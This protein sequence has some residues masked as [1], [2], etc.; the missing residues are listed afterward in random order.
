MQTGVTVIRAHADDPFRA[1]M[2]AGACVINGFGKSVGLVQVDELGVLK[3]PIAL[4]NTFGVGAVATAQIC[5]VIAANPRIGRDW[6]SVNPL[7]FE[8][9]DGYLNDMQAFAVEPAHYDEAL[10]DCREDFAQGATGA[11]RGMSCFEL[12]GGIGTASRVMQ[13]GG[14]AYMVGALVLANFGRLPQLTIAGE[15]IGRQ[16]HAATAADAPAKPERGSIII[17]LA[18]DALHDARQLRRV[19]MRAA[20][21]LARTGSS[22]GHGS[23]DIALAFYAAYTVP[24][25]AAFIAMPLL[26]NDARLDRCSTRRPKA[27]STRSPMRCSAR[28]RSRDA[29]GIGA[30]RSTI[31]SG[32]CMKVLVSV[33]IEGVAGVFH[34]EQ[35]RP[36]N[37][38]YE[39]ARR[40]ITQEANAAAQGAFDGGATQVW[41]NDLHGGLRNLL[42]DLLDRRARF[43]LGKPR[44]LGMM[45]ALEASPD[46]VFMVGYHA[47]VQS[48]G[49]LAHMINS[50]AFA[51]VALLTGDDVFGAQTLPAFPGARFLCVK[52]AYGY[53]SGVTE[54]PPP[55]ARRFAAPRANR[56]KLFQRSRN[57]VHRRRIIA[58]S[59]AR[60]PRRSR[61]SS[62]NGRRSSESIRLP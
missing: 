52:T 39:Q 41:I 18:T 8:C 44:T 25:D 58:A 4:T 24:H 57:G 51:C 46:A 13:A 30:S 21:G 28:K 50:A 19:A 55:H 20:A 60:N 27:S 53:S 22:F 54:T 61:T 36:G 7:A 26:L 49:I 47:R 9:N 31:H 42:P 38:E 14:H 5:A 16:L 12:K 32:H 2:P 3:T 29:M 37:G 1:K 17:I 6:P 34:P 59:C 11:G 33:D 48:P 23:G 35:T 15:A 40:W 10:A 43:V 45:A 56:S 62:A